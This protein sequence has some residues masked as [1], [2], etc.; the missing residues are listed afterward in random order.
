MKKL[1]IWVCIVVIT[2]QG[3]F[4]QSQLDE[5]FEER[6]ELV[7]SFSVE[8]STPK[9]LSSLSKMISIDKVNGTEVVAYANSQEFESFLELGID[10]TPLTAPSMLQQ[11]VMKSVIPERSVND[12]DYYPTYDAYVDMMNQFA[13]DYPDLCELVNI[14]QTGEGRD[15][16]FIHINNELGVDQDEPEFMYT[17]SMHG[18]ELT[19][20]VLMLRLIDHLLSNYGSN[21]RITNLV[22]DI[23]IWIN[24][25]ANPDG[26]FAGGNNTVYGATRANANGV[27]LNRNYADPEDGP[28]PDGYAYQIETLAFMEFAENHHLSMAANFHGGAE[29][30]NYPWD[31]WSQLHADDAWWQYVS[32]EYADTV[33]AHAPSGYLTDLNN[34]ITNGY[35]WYTTSGC[36]Q[37]YMNYFQNCREVTMEVSAQKT[38]SAGLLPSY[39]DYNFRSLLNYMEQSLFGFTGL[40]TNQVNGNPVAAK[41]YINNHDNN[42]SWIYSELPLGDYHRVIKSGIYNVTY[43]ASGYYPKNIPS[44]FVSDRQINQLNVQLEPIEGLNAEFYASKT[45]VGV[46]SPVDFTNESSGVDIV[47][48]NWVF[49]GGSPSSSGEENVTGIEY[50]TPGDYNVSLTVS[51]MNG[52]SNQEVKDEYI[53]V[54]ESYI[55]QNGQASICRALFY[56]AGGADEPYSNN[57]D[58]MF[59]FFPGEAN[60]VVLMDFLSFNVEDEAD[61]NYDYLEIFNGPDDSYPLIGKFCGTNSPGEVR[62]SDVSGALTVHFYSDDSE[63]RL[64]W[65]AV[66]SCDS[67]VGM[68]DLM[69]PQI[70]IY[71][72]PV[73]DL[74]IVETDGFVD[75]VVLT[76]LFGRV[77]YQHAMEG[78]KIS[79]PTMDLAKGIYL[80]SCQAPGQK[81]TRKI[82]VE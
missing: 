38:P 64:G 42:N 20:Y 23:D 30:I 36:R 33:H 66:I 81:I 31:T 25:L 76:D 75:Q 51:D 11:P 61:C 67:N 79:I 57:Q 12:W 40:I 29:V 45:I 8:N 78:N 4:A 71:P 53:H 2:V 6:G 54:Y 13:S 60:K 1:F 9:L 70:A 63:V 28:H 41:V 10:Y 50:D 24:P 18:D 68:A 77:V 72:N 62:S 46:N 17:S 35:A 56:D 58:Y 3:L 14:G 48:W 73:K 37:D 44:V 43:S 65:E 15:L 7:F 5:L 52:F 55:M 59:T 26:T 74:L 19:G 32:R 82:M 69:S 21:D 47:S 16:L 80:I 27:D 49:E 39:W 22:N 34:G